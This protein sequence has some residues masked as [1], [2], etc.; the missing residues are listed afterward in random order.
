MRTTRR[1]NSTR[2]SLEKRQH[3]PSPA[4][5]TVEFVGYNP[6]MRLKLVRLLAVLVALVVP[7]QGMAAL[8]AGQC[9]DLGHHQ[10][11]MDHDGAPHSHDGPPHSHDGAGGHD[12]GGEGSNPHCGPCAACCASAS[13]AG[14]AGVSVASTAATSQYVFSQFAP[15]GVQPD[16]LDR[17]PLAL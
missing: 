10:A 6:A 4:A 3:V 15:I 16:G 11:A 2:N 8:S 1:N 5:G 7:I 14:V 9:M 17:P 12:Q 13:I